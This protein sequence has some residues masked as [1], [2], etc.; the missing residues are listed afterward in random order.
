MSK[1]TNST[2]LKKRQ[3]NVKKPVLTASECDAIKTSLQGAS[4]GAGSAGAATRLRRST[5]GV[6][7]GGARRSG[8]NGRLNVVKVFDERYLQENFKLEVRWRA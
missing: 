2:A 7:R 4:G 8:P 1:A 6:W 3:A 5:G